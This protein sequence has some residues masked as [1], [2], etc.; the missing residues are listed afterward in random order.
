LCCCPN[1]KSYA[2]SA[3]HTFSASSVAGVATLDAATAIQVIYSASCIDE[4]ILGLF[5]FAEKIYSV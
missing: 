1:I 2:K 4:R 5:L 3:T